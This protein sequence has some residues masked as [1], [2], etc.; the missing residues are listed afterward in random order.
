MGD[1]VWLGA[2]SVILPGCNLESGSIIGSNAVVTKSVG[3][4]AIFA[5]VPAKLINRR[6]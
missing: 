6:S 1:D 3:E 2:H 4:N 5:G